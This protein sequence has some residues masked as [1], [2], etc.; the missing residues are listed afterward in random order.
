MTINQEIPLTQHIGANIPFLFLLYL[1]L[2]GLLI[3]G[4]SVWYGHNG[5]SILQRTEAVGQE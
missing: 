1:D 2:V 5:W 3:A 4:L